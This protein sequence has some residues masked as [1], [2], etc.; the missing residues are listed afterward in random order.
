MTG[1]GADS[2]KDGGAGLPLSA[3]ILW[4]TNIPLPAVRSKQELPGIAGGGWLSA[5][6]AALVA[7]DPTAEVVCAARSWPA[8]APFVSDG[9][10]YVTLASEAPRGGWAG[11]FRAWTDGLRD[12]VPV[13]EMRRLIDD[14]RPDLIHVHG[15]ETSNALGAVLA[16]KRTGTPVLV[17]IQGP[18]SEYAPLFFQGSRPEDVLA[19]LATADFLKGGG[20]I[21][22]W[23]RMRRAAARERVTLSQLTDAAGRT[24]WDREVVRRANPTARYWHVGE[25]LRRPFYESEWRGSSQDP[26]TILAV[27]S[28]AP[29]KGIDVLLKA[30]AQVLDRRPARLQ[31][32]G[33]IVGTSLWRSLRR[34]EASLGLTGRVDW[35]GP[36]DATG[37]AERLASCD[38]FVCASRIENSPNSVCE[39]MLVGAPV[40]AS[41]VGGVPS[42]LAHEHDGLLF[43]SGDPEELGAAVARVLADKGLARALGRQARATAM[44]RHDPLTV[45]EGLKRTYAA[46]IT[47][48]GR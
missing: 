24:E 13:E 19:D 32:V 27:T 2:G 6:L 8:P 31:V 47:D 38:V 4:L 40:V 36:S 11:V 7:A 37:V 12:T 10:R 16:A 3:R 17:S 35:V 33:D 29:Y 25:V 20:T 39:A 5:G 28:A 46:L 26:P 44:A 41:R 45:T 48:T 14:T 1:L 43:E 42:L 23:R 30:F 22:S 21:H 9:V 34:L 15:T 18:V